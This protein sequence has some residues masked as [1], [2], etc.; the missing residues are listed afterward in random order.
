MSIWDIYKRALA[1]LVAERSQTLWV[2]VAGVALGIVPIAEQVLLARVVDALALGQ[3]AFPIIG[4]WALVGLVGIV[5]SVI[6]AVMADRLA[7]RRRLAA[8]GPGL[9][10]RHHPADQLPRRERLGR[11]GAHHPGR[12]RRAVLELAVVPARAVRGPDRHS[13]AGADGHLHER[14]HG[15]DPGWRWPSSTCCPTSWWRARPAPARPPSSGTTTTSTAAS[16]TCSATSPWC[17]A[18]RA[19]PPRCRPCA[20]SWPSCWRRSIPC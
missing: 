9:R 4:L 8:L 19:S 2:V 16:A 14:H 3:G 17:R 6:V 11:G 5:A 10:A 20:A 13:R 1:M 15:A 18:T 7:H 12:H